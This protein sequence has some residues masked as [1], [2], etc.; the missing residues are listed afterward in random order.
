MVGQQQQLPVT[1]AKSGFLSEKSGGFL[2]LPKNIL[3]SKLFYPVNGI[4]KISILKKYTFTDFIY[5]QVQEVSFRSTTNNLI[6]L[7]H[8]TY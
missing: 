7:N 2:L 5:L 3:V 6:C 4:D 8:F 1:Y